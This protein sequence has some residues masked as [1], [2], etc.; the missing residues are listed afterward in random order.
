MPCLGQWKLQSRKNS[1]ELL[2]NSISHISDLFV[3]KRYLARTSAEKE[4]CIAK[5][6]LEMDRTITVISGPSDY[7]KYFTLLPTAAYEDTSET[8]RIGVK[9]EISDNEDQ[10]SE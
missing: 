5:S 7:R 8:L 10:L 1:E 6:L 3:G 4:G 9:G 2:K